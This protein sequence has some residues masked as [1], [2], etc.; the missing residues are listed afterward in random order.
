MRTAQS[1][2]IIERNSYRADFRRG[3]TQPTAFDMLSRIYGQPGGAL[4]EG[5]VELVQVL[6]GEAPGQ[7][8]EEAEVLPP[9]CPL[10]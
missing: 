8:E 4:P 10:Q 6:R 9:D 7:R 2:D 3:A 1:A 5:L